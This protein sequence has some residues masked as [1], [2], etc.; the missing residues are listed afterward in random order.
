MSSSRRARSRSSASRPTL[1]TRSPAANTAFSPR[2]RSFASR[3]GLGATSAA[4]STSRARASSILRLRV[5]AH[6]PC[7]TFVY[8]LRVRRRVPA[9]RRPVSHS[10][11]S[12]RVRG[13]LTTSVFVRTM[14][15]A[16]GTARP[17]RVAQR[18][19]FHDIGERDQAA[20]DAHP[21][22]G[23]EAAPR[24]PRS[25][26]PGAAR[27]DPDPGAQR[28]T[29]ALRDRAGVHRRAVGPDRAHPV[30]RGAQLPG[31]AA[32]HPVLGLVPDRTAVGGRGDR[33]AVPPRT[34]ARASS[35]PGPPPAS[36]RPR[37]RDHSLGHARGRRRHHVAA[38]LQPRRGHPQRDPARPRPRRRP[39]LAERSRHRPARGD[40]RR[41]LGGHA[42]DHGRA[43]G[44]A[45][46]HPA[47]T[48]RGGRDG[49]RGRLAPLPDRHLARP[50]T[51]RPRHHGAELHLELQ[52]LRP[53]LCADQRR[54]RRPDPA[55]HALR[56]RRGLPLRAVRL[57][58]GHGLRDGR[59]DL[60][61][62]RD[63]AGRP[64]E[65]DEDA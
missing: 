45:A 59:G 10:H 32:R 23:R 20:G 2:A 12:D 37:P 28:R 21:R 58:G 65:G 18:S 1:T 27:A 64:A 17:P 25:L 16:A 11:R 7:T 40:R 60:G 30:D 22:Y 6:S 52:F 51:D 5:L 9:I 53:G 56:L 41:R 35:R 61:A 14:T 19:R 49:R 33:A 55:P 8:D 54:T 42:A 3:A 31:P 48:P 46:E 38:R 63:P 26:V 57:R 43:A 50:E 44:R 36:A 24:R 34:G 47:R 13:V 29:A 39:R 62:A 15:G 4:A